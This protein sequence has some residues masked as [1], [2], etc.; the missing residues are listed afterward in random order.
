MRDYHTRRYTPNNM[1]L[2]IAGNFDWQAVLDLAGEKCG[3]WGSSEAGRETPEILPEK[4]VAQV[5]VKPG[6]QQQI[7]L[8]AW[9]SVS[10]QDKDLYAAQLAAMIL[11]DGTGSRLFWNVYQKG[12]A[13]TAVA[14]LSPFDRTGMMVTFVSTTPDHAP[15]VLELVHAELKGMQDGAVQEDELRRAKDKLISHTVLDG[16]SPFS[17]MQDLAYTWVA[18]HRLR[19]IEQEMEEIERVTQ[20]DIRR[21][22]DRFPYTDRQVLL[23]Y[24]PLEAAALSVSSPEAPMNGDEE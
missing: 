1:V 14:S 21:V 7:V 13:E 6:Q 17:R 12:L 20:A 8:L 22:L 3:D 18:E 9:P 23:A 2:A 15:G 19:T 11:G 5:I 10:S 16:E 24:G 4:S